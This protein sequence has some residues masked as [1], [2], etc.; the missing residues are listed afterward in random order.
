MNGVK[1]LLTRRGNVVANSQKNIRKRRIRKKYGLFQVLN[2]SKEARIT[3]SGKVA[4]E[5]MV[6]K[7]YSPD[8][9]GANVS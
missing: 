2:Y 6:M 9:H 3:Y 5:S 4:I 8:A 1:K 7:K